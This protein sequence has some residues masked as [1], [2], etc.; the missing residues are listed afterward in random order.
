MAVIL[1]KEGLKLISPLSLSADMLYCVC[2]NTS[3]V[4]DPNSAV[5]LPAVQSAVKVLGQMPLAFNYCPRFVCDLVTQWQSIHYLGHFM[6]V[7]NV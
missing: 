3:L 6:K 5:T 1:I 2:L 4:K 7:L